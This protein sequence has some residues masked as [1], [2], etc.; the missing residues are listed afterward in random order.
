MSSSVFIP[1]DDT[2]T[3]DTALKT[4]VTKYYLRMNALTGPT[5][6]YGG[7]P[8]PTGNT[9]TTGWTGP[10]GPKGN[11][12]SAANT[13]ATGYTGP[14]G[15]TGA[16]GPQGTPGTAANTGATGPTGSI[17]L[18]G[19][20][21]AS[22]TGSTGAIGSTGA[23]GY[24]GPTGPIG[25]SGF[26][27]NTGAT[28]PTGFTGPTG[29]T[30][31][32][33][34]PGSAANTGATGP[35]G[36]IGATGPQVTGATGVTGPTGPQGLTGATGPIGPTGSY[37]L[38]TKIVN[39]TMTTSEII[40]HI[41][42]PS[43]SKIEF[44]YGNYYIGGPLNILRDNIILEGNGSY[45]QLAKYVNSPVIFAGQINAN[46]PTVSYNIIV[47]QNFVIDGNLAFQTSETMGGYP[48]IYNNGIS[49]S[50]CN[51]I[52]VRNCELLNCRSGGSTVTFNSNHIIFESCTAHGNYYDGFTSYSSKDVVFNNCYSYQHTGG[53]GMS[54]D[55]LMEQM[56]VTNCCLKN[57]NLGVFARQTV[58]SIFSNNVIT[59]N[60]THGFFLSGYN[61]DVDDRGLKRCVFSNNIINGNF[62]KGLWLQS[63]VDSTISG[64]TICN[65]GS[66]G[67]NI[68]TYSDVPSRGVSKNLN[69]TGNTIT[70]NSDVGI[71]S[72][73][74]NTSAN[75][76]ANNYLSLNVVKNNTNGQIV[77]E[78]SGFF[79]EDDTQLDSNVVVLRNSSN[80]KTTIYPSAL[81]DGINLFLPTTV[82]SSGQ[83][84]TTDGTGLLSFQNTNS[85]FTTMSAATGT[86]TSLTTTT[87]NITNLTSTNPRFDSARYTGSGAISTLG[88]AQ[89]LPSNP[90]GYV[91]INLGGTIYAIP[92]FQQGF[93]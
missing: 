10:T 43:Y 52:T 22:L 26:S 76:A 59:N 84:L 39:N 24:T 66:N 33:G 30:G 48:Y 88:L 34:T 11:D 31:P 40:A 41:N 29:A 37:A 78:Y 74:N 9:G 17:G 49:I 46:P 62:A 44:Q 92:Y 53:A 85:T 35:T 19:A 70:G 56:A 1:T 18:T 91:A 77:G 67:I 64:N 83:V 38:S 47:I 20:T 25:P 42:N 2:L 73:P 7:P 61:F 57:N 27:T 16:T 13:G 36:S 82:G 58:D 60:T 71:Y 28:G 54:F 89:A 79:L 90:Q 93:A 8:G 81:A 12:G 32:Q 45:L 6:A 68:T 65:N 51:N 55:N 4:F 23:T 87:G 86:I 14:T 63:V 69:I 50:Y 80:K 15:W 3:Y 72:D 75:G 21:G 5:G